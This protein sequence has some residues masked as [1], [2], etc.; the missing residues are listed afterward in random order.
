MQSGFGIDL[1]ETLDEICDPQRMALLV[2][3]MQVGILNQ[4]ANSDQI[5]SKVQRALAAARESGMR[6][7]FCRHMTLPN[8]VSGLV[9]LRMRM[10]WQRLNDITKVKSAFPRDSAQFQIAS[11]LSPLQSEAVFDKI[12]MSAFEGTPLNI[13]LRDCGINAIAVIGVALEVGIEPTVRH[14]ADLGYIPVLLTDACGYGHQK[15]AE[16]SIES[17]KYA[18][19]TVLTA[20]DS[21]V[22]ALQRRSKAKQVA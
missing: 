16:R 9:Q 19:D 17:L 5:V 2:Y 6:V 14:A 4:I 12:T 20:V 1:P 7:F 11:E 10:A 8:E 18:G 13:A 3:D 22:S 21:F 15:A